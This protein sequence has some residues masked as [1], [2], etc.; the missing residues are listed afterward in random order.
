MKLLSIDTSSEVCSVALLE[1]NKVIKEISVEDGNTHSVKLM[2]QIEQLCKETNISL[3]E[4][5]LFACDK[6][7][8]SFTGI[9]IGIATL[10]A[11]C[12][13]L[14]KPAIGVT[15]LLGLAYHI[16]E[17]EYVCSLIDAKHDMVYFS[18]FHHVDGKYIPEM[19]AAAMDISN[20]TEILKSYNKCISFVGNG[21]ILFQDMLKFNLENNA[22]IEQNIQLHKLDATCIGRAAFDL[23]Q[24]ADLFDTSLSPLY[25]RKSNAEREREGN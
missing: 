18:L 1:N 19:E 21:S 23:Y 10:K 24:N 8:G 11:F 2:P 22:I 20:V 16:A 9:R 14:N 17:A 7:P 3:Q 15:S 5:D 4:I 12:D 6:G 13:T 25:L